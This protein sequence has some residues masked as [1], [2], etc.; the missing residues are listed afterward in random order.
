MWHAIGVE[1]A[2]PNILIVADPD[3]AAREVDIITALVTAAPEM[4]MAATLGYA[5]IAELVASGGSNPLDRLDRSVIP[6]PMSLRAQ[7][8][9]VGAALAKGRGE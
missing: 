5:A 3:T 9:F 8:E 1:G 7:L 6:V 2:K 4:L